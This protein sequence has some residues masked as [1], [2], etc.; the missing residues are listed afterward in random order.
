MPWVRGHYAR[1]PRTRQ[2]S[3]TRLV[4]VVLLLVA[5]V[6]LVWWLSR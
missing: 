3:E 6:V 4:I 2:R 1:R 5:L